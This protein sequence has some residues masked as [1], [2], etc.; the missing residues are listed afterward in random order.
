MLRVNGAIGEDGVP[1]QVSVDARILKIVENVKAR[2]K[3][4][5][6]FV[7]MVTALP[8]LG[9]SQFAIGTL[10]PLLSHRMDQLFVEFTIQ[11]F[12][13]RCIDP[14]T[15]EE[16]TII[17]DEGH[18]GMNSGKVA[19]GEFQQMVNILMLVRQK[20][21]NLLIVTQDYFSIAKTIAIFRSNILFHITTNRK[22]KRGS[23]LVFSRNKKKNLYLFGK[24]NLNYGAVRANYTAQFNKN[25]HLIPSDYLKRKADHL[26]E[27]NKN[28]KESG[29]VKRMD[30]AKKLMDNT[31]LNLTK[32]NF[33]QK[34]IAET[35]GIGLRTVTEHWAKMKMR[36][37][38][39]AELLD[40]NK[41]RAEPIIL[42]SNARTSP[43]ESGK[44]GAHTILN[45]PQNVC[46]GD[47]TPKGEEISPSQSND[48]E[49]NKN[50]GK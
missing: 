3:G 13:S 34:D 17:L 24:K 30:I 10:G 29:N 20:R 40:L 6:D 49:L 21:L 42:P 32:R 46:G 45:N 1:V 47:V 16:S 27:Q 44:A 8:G 9:K 43:L 2:K 18:E 38:V 39:P 22:G 48:N 31:I 26:I 5:Y 37:L 28:L 14:K 11:A 35:M 19:Q 7:G 4:G 36:N 15:P 25:D 41:T 50:G 33:R 23:A 12:I